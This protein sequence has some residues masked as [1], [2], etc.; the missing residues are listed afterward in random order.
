MGAVNASLKKSSFWKDITVLKLTGSMRLESNNSDFLNFLMDIGNG[1]VNNDNE[2]RVIFPSHLLVDT[3]EALIYHVYNDFET[4]SNNF[5][6]LKERA[7]LCSTNVGV[8]EI[9][10]MILE[11]LDNLERE[12]L[13]A[14]SLIA[15]DGLNEN[16]YPPE[17]LHSMDCNGVPPHRLKL[18]V[19][20]VILKIV[21]RLPCYSTSQPEFSRRFM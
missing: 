8:K 15:A 19:L 2:N 14:D 16:L 12:Y 11:K 7:I 3:L 18:K 10:D 9:N 21:G 6:Y 20:Y 1:V 17:F 13:S 4:N 5:E